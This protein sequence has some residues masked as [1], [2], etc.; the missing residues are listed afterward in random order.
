M[1]LLEALFD[2]ESVVNPAVKPG[3]RRFVGRLEE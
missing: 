2:I 1:P 3:E